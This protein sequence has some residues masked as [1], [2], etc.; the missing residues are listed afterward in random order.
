MIDDLMYGAFNSLNCQTFFVVSH[1]VPV[2]YAAFDLDAVW[3]V[4]IELNNNHL[5][6][7]HD[8]DPALMHSNDFVP[9]FYCTLIEH[10]VYDR[11]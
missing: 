4:D 9:H 2:A 1:Y 8:V 3:S 10:N 5:L 6:L 11:I 7:I